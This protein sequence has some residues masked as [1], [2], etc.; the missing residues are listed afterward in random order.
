MTEQA[1]RRAMAGVDPQLPFSAVAA[2]DEV[3]DEA[4]ARQRC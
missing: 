4:L 3:K 1:L 2:I